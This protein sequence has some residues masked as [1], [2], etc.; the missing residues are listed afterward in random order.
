MLQFSNIKKNYNL[1][2]TIFCLIL[3]SVIFSK[4]ER[5]KEQLAN[6]S[7]LNSEIKTYKLK[8]GQLAWSAESLTFSKSQ[9]EKLILEKDSKL[10]EMASKFS[11][12]KTITKEV[13]TTKIDSIIIT[14]K[15]TVP[16]VFERNGFIKEKWY[17]LN[18]D[19]NQKQLSIKNVVI[20]DSIIVVTGEKRKWLFGKT[21]NTIDI[22]HSNPFMQVKG[23]QH[24]ETSV[25]KK[26]YETT[27]FKFGSG[28]IFGAV[29]MK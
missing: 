12:V 7:A 22:S 10:K 9:L 26:W 13:T 23:L 2:L 28:F 6:V 5:E 17:Q 15:D 14:Y 11:K 29:L 20:P 19:L 3:C 21:T 27:L 4:C 16:C 25:S 8:N 24:I 18:Y 1:L